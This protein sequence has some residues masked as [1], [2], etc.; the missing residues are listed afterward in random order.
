MNHPDYAHFATLVKARAGID[1]GAQKDYL[2]DARLQSLATAEGHADVAALLGAI[3]VQAAPRVVDA[4]LDAMTT[5]ETLFFRDAKPFEQLAEALIE[6]AA[7]RRGAQIRIWSAACSTGQEPYSIAMTAAETAP[8][9]GGATVSILAT[10]IS[11]RCLAYGREGVYTAFEAQRGLSPERLERHFEPAGGGAWRVR[12]PLRQAI[13]WQKVNLLERVQLLGRFDIVLCR[14]VLIYFDPAT[15]SAVLE[16]IAAQMAPDG[17]LLLGG[18]ETTAGLSA[19]FRPT[20]GAPGL[21]RRV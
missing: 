17:V 4:A 9:L 20:P 16:R 3:R 13:R 11:E 12:E 10:D 8:R 6:R 7:P 15:K 2:I 1:L 21:Q 14:N 18:S 19:R 5:N